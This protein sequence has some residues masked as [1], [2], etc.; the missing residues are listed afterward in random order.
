MLF[1]YCQEIITLEL[2]FQLKYGDMWVK[3]QAFPH[4]GNG[5]LMH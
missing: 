4:E 2:V 1:A 3:F 5:D